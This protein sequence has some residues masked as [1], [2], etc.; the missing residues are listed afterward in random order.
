[1]NIFD[2]S[3]YGNK[4]V[5]HIGDIVG[6]ILYIFRLNDIN[7]KEISNYLMAEYACLFS[8]K[9]GEA[10]IKSE[11]RILPEEKEDFLNF[12]K[13]LYKETENHSIVLTKD[14]STLEMQRRYLCMPINVL[15]IALDDEIQSKIIETYKE[16]KPKV[17]EKKNK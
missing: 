17:F 5:F 1:M 9:L 13:E 14:L 3:K 11:V 8:Q 10:K 6:N 16:E 2:D 4:Y 15:D 7:E 12:N